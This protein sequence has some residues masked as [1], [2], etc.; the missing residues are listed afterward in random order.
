MK[1][2]DLAD[3]DYDSLPGL[4]ETVAHLRDVFAEKEAF[5]GRVCKYLLGARRETAR[6][7][8]KDTTEPCS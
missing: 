8:P 1:G 4:A 3:S 2:G 6:S 5:I 7:L